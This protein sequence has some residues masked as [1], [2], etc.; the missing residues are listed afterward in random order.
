MEPAARGGRGAQGGAGGHI[1]ETS[2]PRG[3]P[4]DGRERQ[5]DRR[6]L[7]EDERADEQ[8][9]QEDEDT[10][11]LGAGQSDAGVVRTL[12]FHMYDRK[13]IYVPEHLNQHRELV[14]PL[15]E[16]IRYSNA[17]SLK[18][19]ILS[20]CARDQMP[21][22]QPTEPVAMGNNLFNTAPKQTCPRP[23]FRIQ[24]WHRHHLGG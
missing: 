3:V 8:P 24:T 13:C 2:G 22:S 21:I 16:Y 5:A 6:N 20:T 18:C 23:A 12:R 4:P 10:V 11:L 7:G 19:A 17:V 15:Y 14:Q 1:K 9:V